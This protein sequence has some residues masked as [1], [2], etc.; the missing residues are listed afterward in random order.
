MV[1]V[2]VD[3]VLM[4]LSRDRFELMDGTERWE[5]GLRVPEATER[6]APPQH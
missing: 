4:L 1:L 3:A 5:G 2:A 6:S